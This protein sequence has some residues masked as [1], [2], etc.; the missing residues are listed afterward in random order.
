MP[1]RKKSW[2]TWCINCTSE[3]AELSKIHTRL[4]EKGCGIVGVESERKAIE[5]VAD[6]ARAIMAENGTNYPNVIV[7]NDNPIFNMVSGYP[8]SIFVDSEGKILTA[9]IEGAAVN[10]Y[11]ATVDKLLAGENV[12]RTPDVDAAKNE[13]GEYRVV[14][15]DQKGQPVEGAVIQLCDDVSCAFQKTDANGTATFADKEQKAYDIHVLAVPEGYAE[16]TNAYKTLDTF[17]DVNIFLV[18]K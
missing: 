12:N 16:D 11:E 4:R 13:A 18:A 6:Q 7:P 14:V 15:Y 9:P 5:A 10:E 8:T 1:W 2:G 3:M 17:S